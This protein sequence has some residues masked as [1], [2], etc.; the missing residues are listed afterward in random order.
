MIKKAIILSAGKGERMREVNN[1]IPKILL[2]VAGKPMIVWNIELLKKHGIEE[3]AINTHYLSE[4]VKEY[5]GDG[6]KFGV[7]IEYSYE[8]ELL[9]TSGA[10]NNFKD[11]FDGPFVVIY[12][13]VIT[14][15]NLS[16]MMGF[17]R[18]KNSSATLVVHKSDHP[19][20]SD[21]AQIDENAKIVKLIHKP[22]NRDFGD[23]GSAALYIVEKKVF[24]YLPDGKSDFIKDVFSKMLEANEPLYGYDTDEFIK[25]AGTPDRIKQVEE[26][27]KNKEIS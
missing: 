26:Y 21:I 8:D 15:M 7:K 24:D 17:H 19:E 13:D 3:I 16:K 11:F 18:A 6:T 4:Q 2:E 12:G 25:D 9:G 23:L 1:E 20:D 10:L 22:G 5:L 14:E 27:L